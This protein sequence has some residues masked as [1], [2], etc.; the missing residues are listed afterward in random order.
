MAAEAKTPRPYD[1]VAEVTGRAQASAWRDAIDGKAA[2]DGSHDPSRKFA[3][4]IWRAQCAMTSDLP[5][6]GD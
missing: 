5:T 3:L 4:E 2:Q 1:L 6:R